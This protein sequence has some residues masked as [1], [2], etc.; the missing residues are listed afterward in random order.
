MCFNT[1]RVFL[2]VD[3]CPSIDGEHSPIVKKSGLVSEN[4][5]NIFYSLCQ[6]VNLKILSSSLDLFAKLSTR[7]GKNAEA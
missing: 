7:D 2:V 6:C 4:I 1:I 3:N 5:E